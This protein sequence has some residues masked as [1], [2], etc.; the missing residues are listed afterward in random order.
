MNQK[1]I[2]VLILGRGEEISEL[3]GYYNSKHPEFLVVFGRRRVGK[4]YLIREHFGNRLFFY[5]TGVANEGIDAQITEWNKSLKRYGDPDP[6]TAKD[7]YEAFDRL[8]GI[9]EKAP[10]RERKVIFLDELPW[11]ETP[12]SGFLSALEH[13]WNGWGAS[14]T[15]IFLIVCGSATSWIVQKL[16]GNKGG[17][18]NRLTGKMYLRPFTLGECEAYYHEEGI[19]YSRYQMIESYMIFGG[20][21]Y[22]LSLMKKSNSLAQNVDRLCFRENAVLNDELNNLYHS[23][24]KNADGHIAIIS[25]LATKT[26]GLSRGEILAQSGLTDGGGFT[27]ILTE[28]EQSGFI[29]K[30]RNYGN[31]KKDALYQLIDFFSLFYLKFIQDSYASDKNLWTNLIGKGE[32]GAWTGY[33]FEQVALAHIDEIKSKLGISG[34][35]SKQYAWRSKGRPGAQIDLVIEREDGVINLCEAKYANGEYSITGDD[36]EDLRGKREVFRAETKT[37]SALHLTM[38]TT[39]GVA[40]GMYADTLQSVVTMEDLFK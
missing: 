13:F 7:W 25:A 21:P 11:M 5:H 35:L 30:Y 16:I 36:D 14:R 22:Y 39:Y 27:R 9:I 19:V 10:G 6:E 31:K 4:T 12:K 37:K 1:E 32:H 33:A 29:R 40:R 38:I 20:I 24:F 3:E 23:L 2:A 34:V 28:L 8:R 15:D 17:L 18:H 26:K